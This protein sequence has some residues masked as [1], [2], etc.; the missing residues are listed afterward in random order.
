MLK[1]L[2]LFEDYNPQDGDSTNLW[3]IPTSKNSAIKSIVFHY[4]SN[5]ETVEVLKDGVMSLP[6]LISD[7]QDD[8][9]QNSGFQFKLNRNWVDS[10]LGNAV[11]NYI[12]KNVLDFTRPSAIEVILRPEGVNKNYKLAYE[13]HAH[14]YRLTSRKLIALD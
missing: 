10:T 9:R 14:E 1:H 13:L 5:G 4:D 8:D 6:G 3:D 12:E 2:I 11:I 7:V